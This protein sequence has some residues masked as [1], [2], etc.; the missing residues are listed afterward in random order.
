MTASPPTGPSPSFKRILVVEDSA[1]VIMCIEF[2][3]ED[4]G[5]QLIG[6]GRRLSEALALA[7]MSNFDA[8]IL[9]VNLDG[10]MSWEVADLLLGKSIP[11][12]FTTGYDASIL[13][14]RFANIPIVRKPFT[15]EE[16]REMLFAAI[17]ARA[18]N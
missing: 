9:D 12:I 11:F 7:R 2:M 5:W 10:E 15:D 1:L 6:P 3:I 13:P 4:L 17:S 16:L 18:P 14:A 8:A